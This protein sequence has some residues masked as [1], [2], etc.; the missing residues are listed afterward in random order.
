MAP[1]PLFSHWVPTADLT[2]DIRT[3][4]EVTDYEPCGLDWL[5]DGRLLVVAMKSQQLRRVERDGTLPLR[6]GLSAVSGASLNDM[7]NA[8]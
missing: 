1:H 4:V 6:A 5:P 2:G 3:E 7:I 8:S